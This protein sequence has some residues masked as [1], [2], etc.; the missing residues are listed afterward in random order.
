MFA[1]ENKDVRTGACR[2][3]AK[4]VEAVGPDSINTF[5]PFFKKA[6]EDEKWRV[7][8]EA[9]ES[10]VELAKHYHN[11]EMFAKHIEP[12][13]M[14]FLKDRVSS[15]REGGV[16]KLGVLINTIKSDWFIT[17]MLP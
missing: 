9:Y 11:P 6:I 2:A 14:N 1:D 10:L 15:V 12:L 13:Y 7:R 17:R 3:A 5:I 8:L 16:E 4:F